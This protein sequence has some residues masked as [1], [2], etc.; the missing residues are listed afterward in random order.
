M[1]LFKPF[2][3]D[4][5]SPYLF[6]KLSKPTFQ[7][8]VERDLISYAAL[9]GAAGFG[10]TPLVLSRSISFKSNPSSLK[11]SS[12]CLPS[13]RARFAAD[14]RDAVHL[15]RAADPGERQDHEEDEK[16]ARRKKKGNSFP[17]DRMRIKARVTGGARC[18]LE[19]DHGSA[20]STS[21]DGPFLTSPGRVTRWE[22]LR[23][24]IIK[25]A[26]RLYR[27]TEETQRIRTALFLLKIEMPAA[28]FNAKFPRN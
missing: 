18:S 1:S 21:G 28:I 9:A 4:A 11:T 20:L 19:R 5:L 12:L 26:A 3:L 27:Q 17:A 23:S 8:N 15:N 6:L 10:M 14:F 13:S 16:A 2:H 24:N 22:R 25:S 7:R